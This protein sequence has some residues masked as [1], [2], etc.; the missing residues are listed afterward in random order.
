MALTI[1]TY[2][3]QLRR[4]FHRD[5]DRFLLQLREQAT[6]VLCGTD[7]LMAFMREPSK[8]N[9]ARV[10][11]CEK[12]ADDVRRALIYDLSQSFVTPI[13]REDLFALS[14]SIDD[15]LDYAYA[16]IHEVEALAVTPDTYLCQMVEILHTGAGEIHRA[17]EQLE[18]QP[19]AADEHAIRAKALE[20]QME[21]LYTRAIADLFNTP[22]DLA[23]VMDILKLR[24]VYRHLLHAAQSIGLASNRISDLVMKFY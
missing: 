24:E 5:P 13:D 9:A 7:A 23:Q 19:R 18:Q 1:D 14:R 8:K 11:V 20:N 17:V 3:R 2:T 6:L 15:I 22:T 4:I 10:R 12:K 21:A 16:T